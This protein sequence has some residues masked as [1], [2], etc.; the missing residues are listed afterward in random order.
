MCKGLATMNPNSLITAASFTPDSLQYPDA[1]VGHLP[2][3][4]WVIQELSPKIFVELGTHSGNSYFSFCQSV[5]E[6]GISTKCYAVDTWQGD[7]HAEKYGEEIFAKVNAHNQEHYAGFSRL[8]RMLFDDAVAYFAAESIELLHI[9]GLHTYVAV[10]HDF[11]TWLPKLAPG[12]VV[13]FHDTNVRKKNFG[14]WKLWEELQ[15]R[16]PNNLEFSHSQGLGILQLNNAPDDKR[17]EWLQPDSP[18]KLHLIN[19]FTALGSRQLERYELNELKQHAASL[20]QAVTL[21]SLII[22]SNS[23]RLTKPLRFL[24]RVLRGELKTAIA[25]FTG[26]RTKRVAKTMR[27]ARN[28]AGY[29]IRGDFDGLIKRIRA[30]KQDTVIASIQITSVKP[31]DLTCWGIMATQHSLFIAH[32]IA[33]RLRGHGWKVDIMTKAPA[34]FHHDWYVVICPQMFKKLP[35]RD[36][37]IVFQMEQSVSSR[38]WT[39]AYLETLE[40]SL[41]VLEYALVNLD[42]MASKGV[43]YP[44]VHYLP[45]GAS[46]NYGDSIRTS[47]KICD[48]LFY[49]DSNSSPRRREMLDTLRQHFNVRVVNEVFSHDMLEIIKQARLVINLHYY[50]NALLE[51]PRIQECLTLGVPV[52]SETAQ[53]QED[54]PELVGAVR[55]FEQG[56]IPAMLNAVKAA[57]EYPV[58]TEK[59]AESVEL[60]VQ[61]FAFM[62]DRFLVAMG[63]LP[64]SHVNHMS[65]PLPNLADR[66]ALSLPEIIA[67]RRIFETE[68]PAGCMV[69]DG[70]RRRPG[71]IGCGLSYRTL[72]QHAMKQGKSQLNVM[73]DDVLLPPDFEVKMA[74]VHE[75]L[76]ARTGKWDVFAGVIASLYPDAKILSVD[77]F[78]D[79]T[80]VTINKMTSM[81]CNIY[82]EKALRLLASWD[83]DN[84][85]ADSNTIDRYLE[86]QA[87]FRFVVTLPFLVRHREEVHS[88]LWGVQNTQYIDMIANSEQ[89]LKSMVLAQH[90]SIQSVKTSPD[91]S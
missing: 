84:L 31:H 59:I 83:P 58:P 3:A 8:L 47:E 52:V 64:T 5:I 46:A 25:P 87:D 43:A 16:Y 89:S 78:K 36:K 74:V 56:S 37:R 82:N 14:V 90:Y 69:F 86:S 65:L 57:L 13:I 6:A 55:F 1:W 29:V 44:H 45:V 34:G 72:A 12:A 73:E 85:D 49:G 81:V 21:A 53:D 38:W 54:Y 66:V 11:E 62:F 20:N 63:F 75:F 48:I 40:S 61:R 24:G 51:M 28:A 41:A 71:W 91:I 23:W 18:E 32:L 10:R 4:A 30:R 19:Y 88:T 22:N 15:A 17:L 27:Q 76:D 7:E 67:R 9:D 77:V 42:F 50:E 79:I 35:P 26:I 33:D 60:S 80:F 70:I 68:R 39:D 2:F